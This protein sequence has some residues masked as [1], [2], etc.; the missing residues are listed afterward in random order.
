MFECPACRRLDLNPAC[1]ACPATGPRAV[2]PV[3]GE[4]LI[5]AEEVTDE[6]L[7][8]D[9]EPGEDAILERIEDAAY[10]V[11]PAGDA[12]LEVGGEDG[13]EGGDGADG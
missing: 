10:D 8:L 9:D 7:S 12:G 2:A 3:A 4:E 11:V 1:D 13:S 6:P 5:L